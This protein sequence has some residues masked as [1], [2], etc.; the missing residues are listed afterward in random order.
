MPNERPDSGAKAAQILT[1]HLENLSCGRGKEIIDIGRHG[2][3]ASVH[4]FYAEIDHLCIKANAPLVCNTFAEITVTGVIRGGHW[5]VLHRRKRRDFLQ[6]FFAPWRTSKQRI[7]LKG[8]PIDAQSSA[9]NA[10]SR[11]LP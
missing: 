5:R 11:E 2:E 9:G 4:A 3:S 7:T 10:L 6:V 1:R 8:A